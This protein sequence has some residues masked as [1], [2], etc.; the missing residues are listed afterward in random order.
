MEIHTGFVLQ[1][2]PAIL[3]MPVQRAICMPL[4]RNAHVHAYA[5]VWDLNTGWYL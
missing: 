1:R 2:E 5:W 3:Y 4:Y